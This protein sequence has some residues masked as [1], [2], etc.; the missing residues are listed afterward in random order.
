[1]TDES[2]PH[3]WLGYLASAL[4]SALRESRE[5]RF[6]EAEG[7]MQRALDAYKKSSVSLIILPD[8]GARR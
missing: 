4:A 2:N 6:N 3:Y 5:S 8:E 1:M 7:I